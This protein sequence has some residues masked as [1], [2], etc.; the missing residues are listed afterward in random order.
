MCYLIALQE[1]VSV[2]GAD[3][4][5]SA[6]WTIL[7]IQVAGVGVG[8][9]GCCCGRLSVDWRQSEF[10]EVEERDGAVKT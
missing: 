8:R 9:H 10:A 5:F 6:V 2:G 1:A 7:R 3:G 4:G